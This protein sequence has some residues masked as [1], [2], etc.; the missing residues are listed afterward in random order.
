MVKY[1]ERNVRNAHYPSITQAI[2]LI[3][4]FQLIV[5]AVGAIFVF[6][7]FF[8]LTGPISLIVIS[9]ISYGVVLKYGLRKTGLAF[10]E[11][12]HLRRFSFSLFYPLALFIAGISILLSEVNN[13]IVYIFGPPRYYIG[14]MIDHIEENLPGSIIY[15]VIIGP[16]FEELLFRGLILRG[17]LERSSIKKAV[18]ISALFFSIY[19]IYPYQY[20]TAFITGV[21]FSWLYVRT[22]SLLSCI[23]AH[24]VFNGLAII[25]FINFFGID[26]FSYHDAGVKFQPLWFDAIGLFATIAGGFLFKKWIESRT[27]C[28]H[29]YGQ[30]YVSALVKESCMDDKKH[31][32]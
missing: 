32:S 17:F 20:I 10:G 4:L 16:I 11:A 13:G 23:I 27:L 18:L 2:W 31:K 21:V 25:A 8:G 29:L 6:V 22:K 9:V 1:S 30:T 24:I 28:E 12:F 26:G 15:M 14:W 5:F 7:T 19:H 3:V